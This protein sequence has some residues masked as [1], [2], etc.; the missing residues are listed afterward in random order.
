MPDKTP[1]QIAYAAYMAVLAL[2]FP[3]DF[4]ALPDTSR[5]AWDAAAQAVLTAFVQSTR[6]I[7]APHAH[8]ADA[9]PS[10]A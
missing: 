6:P 9:P 1:G 4:A 10:N 8:K 3:M 5:L 2:G 7:D